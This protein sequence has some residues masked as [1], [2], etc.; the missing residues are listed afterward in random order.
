MMVGTE[1]AEMIANLIYATAGP[2]VLV[3]GSFT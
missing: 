2:T 3:P 1:Q